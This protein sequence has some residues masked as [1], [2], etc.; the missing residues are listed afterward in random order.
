LPPEL[1]PERG[2]SQRDQ[3]ERTLHFPS[4]TYAHPGADLSASPLLVGQPAQFS[5]A[6]LH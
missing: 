2:P 1:Y 3:N 5:T 4:P 6:L